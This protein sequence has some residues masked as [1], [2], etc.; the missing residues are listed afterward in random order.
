MRSA[1][2]RSTA[3]GANRCP[4]SNSP[5]FATNTAPGAI[6]RE[7]VVTVPSTTVSSVAAVPSSRRRAVDRR[8]DL[9]E[10]E[11]DHASHPASRSA[12][13]ESSRALSTGSSRPSPR[14]SPRDRGRRRGSHRPRRRGR[15]PCGTPHAGSATSWISRS[16]TASRAPAMSA[17]RMAAGSSKRGW[18]S[19]TTTTS[20]PRAAIAPISARF[21]VSR[22][23]SAPK[24]M[25]S[26]PVVKRRIAPSVCR[27]ASGLWP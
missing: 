27:K 15:G 13:F 11:G 22:S 21:V 14:G 6:S 2:P 20:A 9:G 10:G 5:G 1:A 8:G 25:M 17:A 4:S 12:C 26:R 19:V 7:S 3:D 16:G 23:P 18:K 24:T